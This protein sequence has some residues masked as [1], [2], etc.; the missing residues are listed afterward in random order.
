VKEVHLAQ[1]VAIV[2]EVPMV[3]NAELIE[4]VSNVEKEA[5]AVEVIIMDDEGKS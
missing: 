4:V 1:N 5:G 3:K 2:E